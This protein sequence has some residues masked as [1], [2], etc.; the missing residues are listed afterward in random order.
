MPLAGF[1]KLAWE[2]RSGENISVQHTVC[3]CLME[4]ASTAIYQHWI[5]TDDRTAFEQ[6][7]HKLQ[8]R[9]CCQVSGNGASDALG[10]RWVP[11]L[12]HCTLSCAVS[13]DATGT[14]TRT[15]VIMVLEIQSAFLYGETKRAIHVELPKEDR[16]G[17]QPGFVAAI[18]KAL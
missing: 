10:E 4:F 18:Q 12:R 1:R 15:Q 14:S 9:K 7:N 6:T 3:S 16:N 2:N 8:K 5:G 17:G 13:P 11:G